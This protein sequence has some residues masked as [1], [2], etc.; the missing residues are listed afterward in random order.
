[1]QSLYFSWSIVVVFVFQGLQVFA[2]KRGSF[3]EFPVEERSEW[4]I[5]L[6]KETPSNQAGDQLYRGILG[7]SSLAVLYFLMQRLNQEVTLWTLRNSSDLGTSLSVGATLIG[8]YLAGLAY[9]R[10]L[11]NQRVEQGLSLAEDYLTQVMERW[12]ETHRQSFLAKLPQKGKDPNAFLSAI[13]R[14]RELGPSG[15]PY[16]KVRFLQITLGQDLCIRQSSS[17][18]AQRH[19]L[20]LAVDPNYEPPR[21]ISRLEEKRIP[22]DQIEA[23][24]FVPFDPQEEGFHPGRGRLILRHRDGS[25]E[26]FSMQAADTRILVQC[27]QDR[28][29]RSAARSTSGPV[30][31]GASTPKNSRPTLLVPGAPE[32]SSVRK[33]YRECPSC[34]EEIRVLARRCRYCGDQVRD[35]EALPQSA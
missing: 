4:V 27:I 15:V 18:E 20:Y 10:V 21:E 16:R 14:D 19:S 22:F 8:V 28:V 24:Q 29:E 9:L 32:A 2:S 6:W 7:A 12:E 23:A 3:E 26:K 1:M 11:A 25:E 33:G 31:L 13:F 35:A 17:F 30:L 34:A 5:R